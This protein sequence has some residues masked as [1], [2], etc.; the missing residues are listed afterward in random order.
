MVQHG[1]LEFLILKIRQ[2]LNRLELYIFIKIK[3]E[4]KKGDY[5]DITKH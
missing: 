2:F 3:Y 4:Y 5:Y 1:N